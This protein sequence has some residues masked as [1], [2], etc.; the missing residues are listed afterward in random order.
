MISVCWPGLVLTSNSVIPASSSCEVPVAGRC[1]E[2]LMCCPRGQVQAAWL[3]LSCGGHSS[4]LC[5]SSLFSQGGGEA[6]REV[7]RMV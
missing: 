7:D 4:A 3:I 5:S 1:G 6:S 2:A